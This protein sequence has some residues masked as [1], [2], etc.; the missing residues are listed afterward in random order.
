MNFYLLDNVLFIRV[1]NV[2]AFFFTC[3]SMLF[4]YCSLA[5]TA[6]RDNELSK[7]EKTSFRR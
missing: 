1:V 7:R 2:I 5:K 3:L 6:Q 4:L